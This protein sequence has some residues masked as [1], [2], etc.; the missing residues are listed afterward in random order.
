MFKEYKRFRYFVKYSCAQQMELSSPK[1]KKFLI[2]QEG[3]YR[4]YKS[5]TKSA[6]NKFLPL[7]AIFTAVKRKETPCDYLNAM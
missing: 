3:T 5:N 1:L 7:F 4:T 6:P 2:F